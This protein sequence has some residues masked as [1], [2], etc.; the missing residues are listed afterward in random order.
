MRRG[1]AWL[2]RGRPRDEKIRDVQHF[3]IWLVGRA[4]CPTRRI[5][6]PTYICSSQR[7][8]KAATLMLSKIIVLKKILYYV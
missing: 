6:N 5:S 2:T 1:V 7:C 4:A 3:L 8:V